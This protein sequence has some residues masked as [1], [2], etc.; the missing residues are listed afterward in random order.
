VE[1]HFC[2]CCV[3]QMSA[4]HSSKFVRA[5]LRFVKSRCYLNN[6]NRAVLE[7]VLHTVVRDDERRDLALLRAVDRAVKGRVTVLR[8]L[9]RQHDDAAH[10]RGN[11]D[12]VDNQ[13]PPR[14]HAS[15]LMEENHAGNRSDQDEERLV[16][17]HEVERVVLAQAKIQNVNASAS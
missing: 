3:L 4:R 16:N 14:V 10:R 7:A 2:E 13:L 11:A 12:G 1:M 6:F 9:F 17:G 5:L 15:D 8:V